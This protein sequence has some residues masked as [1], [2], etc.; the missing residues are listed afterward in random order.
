[1][2]IYIVY[3]NVESERERERELMC[4]L[5]YIHNI[6][7]AIYTTNEWTDEQVQNIKNS[8]IHI[9]IYIYIYVYGYIK[10]QVQVPADGLPHALILQAGWLD[11]LASG[12]PRP[13]WILFLR[14][15]SFVDVAFWSRACPFNILELVLSTFET[16]PSGSDAHSVRADALI[17]FAPFPSVSLCL[18]H[19]ITSFTSFT[20]VC[21]YVYI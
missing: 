15:C 21:I 20:Y 16:Q 17:L 6:S 14:F 19:R 8:I 12:S 9:D 4:G 2:Y 1:M 18:R 5:Q 10:I 13:P 7:Y 11:P 3:I